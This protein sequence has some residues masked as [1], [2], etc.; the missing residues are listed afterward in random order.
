MVTL[1][2]VSVVVEAL[3]LSPIYPF[4]LLLLPDASP[5]SI[6]NIH[7]R[8]ERHV[9]R[10]LSATCVQ[11]P[12]IK[13]PNLNKEEQAAEGDKCYAVPKEMG[14]YQN[15][16]ENPEVTQAGQSHADVVTRIVENRMS[17]EKKVS[18][19]PNSAGSGTRFR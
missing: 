14:I 6:L 18:P 7:L 15:L 9:D 17:F 4:L 19:P 13:F 16:E 2:N 1:L 5:A 3:H 12:D 11:V 10:V 8:A